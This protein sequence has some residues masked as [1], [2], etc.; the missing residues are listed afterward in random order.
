MLLNMFTDYVEDIIEDDDLDITIE[1]INFL[2][3][4][5][6]ITEEVED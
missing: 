3:E 6:G 4:E 2:K 5:Y 1:E